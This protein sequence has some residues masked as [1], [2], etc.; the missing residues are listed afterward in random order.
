MNEFQLPLYLE[1]H[2]TRNFTVIQYNNVINITIYYFKI[3]LY[4]HVNQYYSEVSI[5]LGCGGTL[6]D[7]LCCI[8]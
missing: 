6:P 4:D 5:L 7:D 1:V 8:F 3:C 2:Q